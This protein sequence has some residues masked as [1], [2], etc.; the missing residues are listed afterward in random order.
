MIK[1]MSVVNKTLEKLKEREIQLMCNQPLG[2]QILLIVIRK[3]IEKYE[4]ISNRKR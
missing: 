3:Q 1:N 2:Y 4:K